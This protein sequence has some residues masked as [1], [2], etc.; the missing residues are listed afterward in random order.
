MGTYFVVVVVVVVVDLEIT[1]SNRNW[2]Y[3]KPLRLL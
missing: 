3:W 2:V 1:K